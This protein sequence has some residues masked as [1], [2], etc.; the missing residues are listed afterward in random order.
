MI[1]HWNEGV[2]LGTGRGRK[3]QQRENASHDD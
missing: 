1:A 3:Q 2:L